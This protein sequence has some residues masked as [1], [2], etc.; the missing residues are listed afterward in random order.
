MRALLEQHPD[1]CS[2]ADPYIHSLPMAYLQKHTVLLMSIAGSHSG[3]RLK[4]NKRGPQRV[5]R[6]V[7]QKL[8]LMEVEK[9]DEASSTEEE[10]P[11]RG[12]LLESTP[13]GFFVDLPK[14]EPLPPRVSC[15]N[16]VF[17]DHAWFFAL[18]KSNDR[19]IRPLLC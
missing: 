19:F 3:R 10:E 15:Q 4:S 6:F 12:H 7:A 2:R 18:L 8:G 1:Y 16:A 13:S 9:S 17:D 11:A 5:V 14:L